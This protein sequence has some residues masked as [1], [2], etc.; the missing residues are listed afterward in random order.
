MGEGGRYLK[1]VCDMAF[2]QALLSFLV[3][4]W[5]RN[6]EGE[7]SVTYSLCLDLKRK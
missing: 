5:M 3:T 6:E 4:N 2:R 7:G 1:G